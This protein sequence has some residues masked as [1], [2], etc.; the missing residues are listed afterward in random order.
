MNLASTELRS[1]KGGIMQKMLADRLD[2]Q[3]SQPYILPAIILGR[4]HLEDNIAM[5]GA[6]QG[7]MPAGSVKQRA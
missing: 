3:N 7:L 2:I 4:F 5:A 1:V 6:E